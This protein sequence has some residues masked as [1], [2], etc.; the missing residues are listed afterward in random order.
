PY[1]TMVL[2]DLGAEV[3]KIERPGTG[4][5]A[6]Q[7]GPFLPCGTSAYF[8]SVNRGKK[9]ITLD[10]HD[11]SD[12]ETVRKLAARADIFVENFRPGTMDGYGL[13]SDALRKLNPALIYASLSGFGRT[14]DSAGRPAYD[15]IIQA[16]SGLMSITGEDA[17]RPVRVGTSISDILTGLFAAIGI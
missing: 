7:F 8:A 12:V 13:S 2:A 1:C 6:R 10:L 5:D 15:I 16:M 3:V 4:D 9:S 11:P 17:S 14:G